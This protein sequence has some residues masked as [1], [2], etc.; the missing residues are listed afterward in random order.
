[1]AKRSLAIF[2]SD[3]VNRAK[4][5]VTASALMEAEESHLANVM[6]RG[7]PRGLPV[8]FQ[9]DMHRPAGWSSTLGHFIDGS[10]VRVVGIIVEPETDAEW[11]QLSDIS[12]RFWKEHH[13]AET[14]HP[15]DG[16]GAAGSPGTL[17]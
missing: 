15:S 12:E 7:L 16:I 5:R 14:D 1:M 9:H 13:T 8:N 4:M 2:N 3:Q 17:G 6:Q 10:M 11:L